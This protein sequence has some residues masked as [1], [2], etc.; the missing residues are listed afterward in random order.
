MSPEQARGRVVDARTD[1]WAFG[2]VVF[3]MATGR[4]PFGGET[5]TDVLGAIVHKEPD[6][7]ALPHDA[8]ASLRRLLRRC[9][10]KDPKER[11]HS[12]ADARLELA[13][14][15]TSLALG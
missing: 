12:I 13:D 15:K 4:P 14:L 3:E 9:L 2:C 1:V 8:P 10:T 5:I 11:L 7:S 6:W